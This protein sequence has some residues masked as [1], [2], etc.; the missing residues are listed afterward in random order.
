MPTT[1]VFTEPDRNT[2]WLNAL[3]QDR[4]IAVI[5]APTLA[6]G[7]QMAAAVARGGFRHLEVTCDSEAPFE[8]VQRLTAAW[9]QCWVGLG[10]LVT[11]TQLSQAIAI[12]AAFGFS[13]IMDSALLQQAIAHNFALVTGSLTPNEIWQAWQ[14]GA[15][16]VKVFPVTAM[17]GAAYLKNLRAPLAGISLIPTGGIAIK[18]AVPLLQ[19]GAMAIGLGGSLFPPHEVAARDWQQIEQRA[20]AVVQSTKK[21]SSEKPK[22]QITV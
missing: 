1:E 17:G 10:T 8:L 21:L 13:P 12:K 11:P 20:S 6:Q 14:A 7:E 22:S 15:P 5:R 18:E 19:A 16:A 2:P 9:P 3:R 4:L